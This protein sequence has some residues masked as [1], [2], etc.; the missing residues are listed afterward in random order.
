MAANSNVRKIYNSVERMDGC[1]SS[2]EIIVVP[3]K[4]R[5]TSTNVFGNKHTTTEMQKQPSRGIFEKKCSEDM[6]E[7]HRRTPC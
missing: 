5:I 1:K 3:L 2:S 4:E 6:Q 7:I